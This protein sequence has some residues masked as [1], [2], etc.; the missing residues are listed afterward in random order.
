MHA[1][2]CQICGYGMALSSGVPLIC[3]VCKGF[4]TFHRATHEEYHSC[5]TN[6]GKIKEGE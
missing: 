3:P 2:I 5:I 4:G 1:F 6:D